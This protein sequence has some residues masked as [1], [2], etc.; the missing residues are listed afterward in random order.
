MILKKIKKNKKNFKKSVDIGFD[1]VYNHSCVEAMTQNK[2]KKIN[3]LK[4]V[5]ST[6]RGVAQFG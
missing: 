4:F 2:R 1:I 3:D 6:P 5:F